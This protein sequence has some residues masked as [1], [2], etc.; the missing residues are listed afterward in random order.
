MENR[1]NT[2]FG[3]T[4]CGSKKCREC[5]VNGNCETQKIIYKFGENKQM[6]KITFEGIK[7]VLERESEKLKVI[8]VPHIFL[9]KCPVETESWN[10]IENGSYDEIVIAVVSAILTFSRASGFGADD[11]IRS[12]WEVINAINSGEKK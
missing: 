9:Y 11:I 4:A 10:A 5:S 8:G 2:L 1:A 6:E 12:V 7:M 3:F